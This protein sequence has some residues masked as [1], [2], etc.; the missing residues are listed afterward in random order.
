MSRFSSTPRLVGLIAALAGG[1][2]ASGLAQPSAPTNLT[3]SPGIFPDR[4]ALAWDAVT[5]ADGYIVY[6]GP[7]ADTNTAGAIG[8]PATHSFD[9]TTAG[10]NTNYFYWVAAS[11]A[12]GAG[13]WSASNNGFLGLSAPAALDAS[14]GAYTDKVAI[15]WTD[16]PGAL[17]Y[18]V[19]RGPSA[20]TNAAGVIASVASTNYDDTN[21]VPGTNY[22]YWAQ[23]TNALAVSALSVSN[24]GFR[25]LTNAPLAPAALAASGG[26]HT[27]K[28]AVTWS[29]AAGAFGYIVSRGTNDVADEAEAIGASAATGWDDTSAVPGRVYYYWAAASNNYGVSGLSPSNTGWRGLA[30]PAFVAASDG[31]DPDKVTVTWGASEGARLYR[32][33]RAESGATGAP[34][35][36]GMAVS[37]NFND[38][39]AVPARV[40]CYWTRAVAASNIYS[41]FSPSNTGWRAFAPPASLAASDGAYTDKVAVTWSAAA[42]AAGYLVYRG[43]SASTGAASVIGASAVTGYN[44]TAVAVNQTNYY[45]VRATNAYGQSGFSPSNTGWRATPPP[46]PAPASLSASDGA[47]T[48]KVALTW[49]AA[50]GAAGY[51]VYRGSSADTNAAGVIGASAAT[52]YDDLTAVPGTRYYY[53][54]RAT[55]AG[56]ASAFSPS[57]TGWRAIAPIPAPADLAA[58]DGTHWDKVALGWAPASGATSYRV[59]RSLTDDADTAAQIGATAT[60]AYDDT[61]ATNWPETDLYYWVQAVNAHTASAFSASA[62]GVCAANPAIKVPLAG[63]FD[64]DLKNDLAL[65]Q[66]SSGAWSV[67]L[68]ASGYAAAA[69][70][71]GGLGYTALAADFDGDRKADPG[72]YHAAS[73]GWQIMLSGSGYLLAALAEFGGAN[74]A[75]VA[76]DFDGDL[77]ADPGVYNTATGGWLIK[78]S[79][80]G[81]GAAML[82]GFGGS[83]CAAVTVDLDGDGRADPGFYETA[84]GGWTVMLSGSG[85]TPTQITDFG[86]QGY[87]AVPGKYDHDTR[88]DAAIYEDATGHWEVMLSASAF[89]TALLPNFGGPGFAPVAGD[90]DGDGKVDP[91]IYEAATGV[92]SVKLSGSGYATVQ[93]QQ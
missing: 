18:A 66:Q 29:A 41:E 44:D 13:D 39:S 57:D 85:Y 77:K 32:V 79:A 35:L 74:Q 56:G 81:Y 78:L 36:I 90:F 54:A 86:G 48:D 52:S 53:W 16:S 24:M 75:A 27:D 2:S 12:A 50:A 4:V 33:F 15:A 83:G 82:T 23:A 1:L 17:G 65:Y 87:R 76:A 84:T 5:N 20:D 93:A 62:R 31:A 38:T 43:S 61:G 34:G 67:K 92:W 37:T 42:G 69:A 80:S 46:P 45:W 63:D 3:A 30:P 51:L 11:N 91:A 89:I 72:V 19:Y 59:Y 6:R 47:Y 14:D 9:D 88:A 40:Y 22:Y 26:A 21:A 8:W 60:A 10:H 71:L 70:V 49:P 55:N 7:S 68:S 28:V 64:G 58:S 73:G 25:G